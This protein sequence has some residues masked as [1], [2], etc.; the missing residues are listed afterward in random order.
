M[1][2][3]PPGASGIVFV[4]GEASGD[5]LAAPVVE[6]LCQGP[7]PIACAGIGGD[8]MV[9]AGFTPW[10]HV[11]ELSVRGYWEVLRE[12]PRLLRLRRALASRVEGGAFA[13]LVGVDAPDFNLALETAVH[14]RGV[15]TVHYVSPSIWAWR[16]ERI[17]RIRRAA[18]RVLL[19]FPFEEAIYARCGIPATYV[20]HPL[21]SAI[22]LQPDR[23]AARTR[24]GYGVDELLICLMP[25]SRRA[26]IISIAPAFFAAAGVL[27]GTAARA[28]FIVPV[29]DPSLRPLIEQ[30]RDQA[31]AAAR[32]DLIDGRSHD[33][34][35]ACDGVLVASGTATLEAALYKRPMV[36]AYR[37]PAVSAWIMRRI[38]GYL[39]WVGLPNI[40]AGE[41]LVPELLQER[42]TARALAQALENVLDNAADQ[43]SLLEKFT[44]MHESLRRDTPALAA[45]A[46]LHTIAQC[47][48][49]GTV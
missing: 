27:L 15:P 25:G 3:P 19:V 12:L 22:P 13:A 46:I 10:H 14:R 39:P 5:L 29:A 7:S 49:G 34:L 42:A 9:R 1:P 31:P 20:G 40:L 2:S 44:R 47:R 17:E 26:E 18:D 41:S 37:M 6:H 45:E 32:I 8:R 30:L 16:A 23:P 48:A 4:A 36:I 35:E 38:G 21:A 24:L 28:R 11:R 33:C 43:A